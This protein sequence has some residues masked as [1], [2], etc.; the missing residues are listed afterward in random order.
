MARRKF[1]KAKK[2]SKHEVE[3]ASKTAKITDIKGKKNQTKAVKRFVD[4]GGRHRWG[5]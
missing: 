1:K 3:I 4:R 5:Q 2:M